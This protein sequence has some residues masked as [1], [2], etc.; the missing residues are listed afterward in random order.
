MS[1]TGKIPQKPVAYATLS[2][3][4]A[5][6]GLLAQCN[7]DYRH[8]NPKTYNRREQPARFR[9]TFIY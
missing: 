4:S 5:S 2:Q 9:K 7:S 3:R 1:R 6:P 8:H